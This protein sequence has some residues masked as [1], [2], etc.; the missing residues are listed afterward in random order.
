MKPREVSR[1]EYTP[2]QARQEVE[3]ANSQKET[4]GSSIDDAWIHAKIVAKLI[5]DMKTPVRKINVDVNNNVVTLRGTVDTSQQMEEA[6]RIAKET[7]GVK[8]VN[9]RLQVSKSSNP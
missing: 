8:Q 4:V 3:R 1:S 2:E 6:E 9:N 7:E 5:S